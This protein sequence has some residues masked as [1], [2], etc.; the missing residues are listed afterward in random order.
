MW[1][2]RAL[3]G[4]RLGMMAALLFTASQAAAGPVNDKSSEAQAVLYNQLVASTKYVS[5]V[6]RLDSV[7]DLAGLDHQAADD[8]VLS[9][10]TGSC[11]VT[12]VTVEGRYEGSGSGVAS[13]VNLQ[14][15]TDEASLPST[16]IYQEVISGTALGYLDTGDFVM[17]MTTP[18]KLANGTYWV[19]VQANI[20][21]SVALRTW[22]W[23][24]NPAQ[25]T[26]ESAWQNP[27]DG[28]G[29]GCK[30]W[31][32][33]VSVCE[34]QSSTDDKDLAFKLDGDLNGGNPEPV[35]L[36]LVPNRAPP[37]TPGLL[38]EVRGYNFVPTSV[39]RWDVSDRVTTYV[40][41]NRLLTDITP[42]DLASPSM[43]GVSVSVFNPLLL[44]GDGGLSD[45]LPFYIVYTALTPIIRK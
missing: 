19:S 22:L 26:S 32:P 1:I 5:S 38:L 30:T 25:A 8:F 6:N 27:L 42:E 3:V 43:G 23:G 9:A 37:G 35:L 45:V 36:R 2:K 24:E 14:F 18:L 7:G 33:R 16:L 44:G 15:Y 4:I 28:Y 34:R 11:N 12:T 10:C 13:S 17:T 21:Y 20:N 39:V 41:S 40:N 31:A 29:T